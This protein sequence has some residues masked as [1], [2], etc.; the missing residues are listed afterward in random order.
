MMEDFWSKRMRNQIRKNN[1]AKV[2]KSGYAE[3][4]EKKA[5]VTI[6][7][8]SPGLSV[9]SLSLRCPL[10]D[11]TLCAYLTICNVFIQVNA[12]IL[13]L[14]MRICTVMLRSPRSVQ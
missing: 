14:W 11:P 1:A 4:G 6:C 10:H 9:L 3:V 12:V 7:Q 13:I 2:W 5:C 8:S